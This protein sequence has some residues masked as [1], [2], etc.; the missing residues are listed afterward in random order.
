MQQSESNAA[1]FE[2]RIQRIE[3][4][5]RRFKQLTFAALVALGVLVLMGQAPVKGRTVEAETIILKDADGKVRARLATKGHGVLL[6]L[7]DRKEQVRE[8]FAVNDEGSYITL[9]DSTGRPR[10][11]FGVHG[12][13]DADEAS[14][15][16]IGKD[17]KSGTELRAGVDASGLK[18]RDAKGNV[19]AALLTLPSGNALSLSDSGAKPRALLA[20]L[21]GKPAL[22]LYD[23]SGNVTW[24][25]P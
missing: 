14:L 1:N 21:E 3:R 4:Q 9:G 11:M 16:M 6:R 12:G 5:N 10:M 18:I 25:T 22:L 13:G 8:E 17:G 19:A 20:V 7:F 23:R 2:E 15:A 24:H